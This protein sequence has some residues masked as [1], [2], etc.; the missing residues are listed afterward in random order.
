MKPGGIT[1]EGESSENLVHTHG[2]K[3]KEINPFGLSEMRIRRL[4]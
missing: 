1:R 2:T 3:K 4:T